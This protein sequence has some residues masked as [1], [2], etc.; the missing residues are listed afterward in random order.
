MDDRPR[1]LTAPRA[2][3]PGIEERE[4]RQREFIEEDPRLRPVRPGETQPPR[5]SRLGSVLWLLLVLLIIAGLVTWVVIRSGHQ[6]GP[7]G[8]FQTGGPTPVGT[9]KVEKGDMSVTLTALGTVTPLAMGTLK[10]Q[11]NGHLT[12]VAFQEGQMVKK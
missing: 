3:R 2:D 6:A 7:T 4:P 10:T 11:I 9:A 8:R 1:P 12:E 5:R